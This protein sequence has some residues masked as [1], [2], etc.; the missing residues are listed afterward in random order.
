MATAVIVVIAH[1]VTCNEQKN[2][3]KSII[4]MNYLKNENDDVQQ[5]DEGAT[6]AWCC[7]EGDRAYVGNRPVIESL[8]EEL[9]ELVGNEVFV[10]LKRRL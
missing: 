4:I 6:M 7:T 1:E 3:C 10:E 8:A 5:E 9:I 2:S